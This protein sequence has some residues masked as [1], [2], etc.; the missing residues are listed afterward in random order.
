MGKFLVMGLLNVE[1]T[2]K[3]PSIPMEHIPITFPF[4]GIKTNVSGTSFNVSKAL[5]VLGDEVRLA[6]IIGKDLRGEQIKAQLKKEKISKDYI[7]EDLKETPE[8][9]ILYD[10]KGTRQIFCDLKDA[11]EAEYDKEIFKDAIKDQDVVFFGN[12]NFC[13]P[14]LKEAKKSGKL[15]AASVHAIKS[16]DDEFNKDFMEAADILFVSDDN[17]Q[18]S[19]YD[20]IEDIRAKYHNKIIVLGRG[21]KGAM[22]YSEK[23]RFVGNFPSVKTRQIVN[24]VGAGEALSSAFLHFYLKTKSPY[25]SIKNAI[26]F[27]S[28][29]IG[30]TG[31]ANGF[32]TE[33]QI[34]K[35]YSLI[36]K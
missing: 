28:Y 6:S 11:Q 16:S 26:L 10:K 35:F 2:M 18:G 31:S 34:E 8:S 12:T 21:A 22:L 14:F 33:E 30:T 3:V 32:L 7:L 23:D 17:L 5:N 13:R 29:K 4:F 25:Q 1:T 9:I 36:W 24:T 15:V 20:F 27:A 19:P